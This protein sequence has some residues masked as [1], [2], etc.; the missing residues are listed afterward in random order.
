[1]FTTFMTESACLSFGV[2]R[3]EGKYIADAGI[4][5]TK[6]LLGDS[7]RSCSSC[8]WGSSHTFNPVRL[9]DD[10]INVG[11]YLDD[12]NAPVP[13]CR[14]VVVIFGRTDWFSSYKKV[15]L[16][17]PENISEQEKEA[18]W[19]KFYPGNVKNGSKLTLKVLPGNHIGF[20]VHHKLYSEE[21]LRGLGQYREK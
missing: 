13:G 14:N 15:N 6:G 18:F 7:F 19:T 10:G 16:K 20:S 4:D 1:M 5:G 12:N 2:F 21:I 9:Y 17:N 11:V 3:G 8:M